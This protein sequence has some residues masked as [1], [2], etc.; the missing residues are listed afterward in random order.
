MPMCSENFEIWFMTHGYWGN[1]ADGRDAY[2]ATWARSPT[3][4]TAEIRV[5]NGKRH[6]VCIGSV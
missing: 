5:W 1:A 4:Q 2:R 3:N 6:D